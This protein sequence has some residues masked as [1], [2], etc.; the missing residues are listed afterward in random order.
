VFKLLVGALAVQLEH[1]ATLIRGEIVAP[2]LS[3]LRGRLLIR[4]DVAAS[5][6]QSNQC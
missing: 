1:M 2:L 3:V 6:H 4:R 5:A